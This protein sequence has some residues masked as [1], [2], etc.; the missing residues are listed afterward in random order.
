MRG[1]IQSMIM[2]LCEDLKLWR[3]MFGIKIGW[4][5][6]WYMPCK[7][8]SE[9]KYLLMIFGVE[10]DIGNMNLI[11]MVPSLDIRILGEYKLGRLEHLIHGDF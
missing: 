7:S 9:W 2:C 8:W 3:S 4:N 5:C 10:N 11:S 1:Y 6:F